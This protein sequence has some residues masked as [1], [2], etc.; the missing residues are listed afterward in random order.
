MTDTH[1]QPFFGQKS[2]IIISSRQ[3]SDPFILI[4]C[5]KKKADGTWEKHHEGKAV[6]ISIKEMICIN[7]VLNKRRKI[8]S[9]FHSFNDNKTSISFAWDEHDEDLLWINIDNYARPLNY[10]DTEFLRLLIQHLL[11][12]KIE[13]ATLNHYQEKKEMNKKTI[14]NNNNFNTTQNTTH[15]VKNNYKENIRINGANLN[16]NN[17]DTKTIYGKIKIIREKAILIQLEDDTELW[18]P[19]STILSNFNPNNNN[20]QSFSVK[21]WILEKRQISNT[22]KLF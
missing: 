3:K 20:Y 6:K 8:W 7:D 9:T 12:E 11:N 10:P 18:L 19:K 15:F 22:P 5:I 17:N 21:K 1:H 2:G 4:K 13:Y 16:N 14:N